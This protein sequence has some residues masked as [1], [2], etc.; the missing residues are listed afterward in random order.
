[1]NRART[2][3]DRLDRMVTIAGRAFRFWPAASLV[4]LVGTVAAILFTFTRARLYKSETLILY[5]EGLRSGDAGA[6]E[7]GDPARKLALRLKEMALSRLR[8]QQ[9]IDEYKLYPDI[10]AERGTVDAVDEMRSHI[11]FR[12]KD[13]DTFGLSFEGDDPARVQSITARLGVALI[14]EN[15]KNRAEQAEATREM[16][17]AERKHAD[18]ELRD[19]EAALNRFLTKHPEFVKEAQR[20]QTRTKPGLD[21]TLLALE[22]EASRLQERLGSSSSPKKPVV[23]RAAPVSDAA[24]DPRLVT[25]RTAA[26]QELQQAQRDL[27]EKLSQFTDQHPDVKAARAVVLA[28]EAKVQRAKDA[29]AAA[30]SSADVAAQQKAAADEADEGIIDRSTLESQLGKVNQEIAD[31]KNRQRRRQDAAEEK[32]QQQSGATWIVALENEWSQLSR[33]VQ[34][35]RAHVGQLNEKQFKM[36]VLAGNSAS[37]NATLEIIDPAYRPTHPS[38]PS[39][40]LLLIVGLL[41]SIGLGMA[42]ALVLALMDDRLYDRID[43]EQLE[44]LPLLA[45][46]PRAPREKL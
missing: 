6:L 26:E 38:K 3:R 41:L 29:I 12:V 44:L 11:A 17:D 28:A 22:R 16:L 34:E 35:A 42:A 2:A 21:P 31:Y 33:D 43:V 23:A 45:V 39:R 10:M 46:V 30:N 8:L 4:V 5:S 36:T 7:P 32:Q 13:G 27:A 25:A 14:D 15:S 37:R 20:P 24:P 9:I 40:S 18:D 1:M 19:K